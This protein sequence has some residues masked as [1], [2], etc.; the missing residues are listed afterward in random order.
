MESIEIDR[1]K[2]IKA[3]KALD[4][5]KTPGPDGLHPK[6][7]MEVA[8]QIGEPVHMIFVDS[9]TSC[10]LPNWCVLANITALYKGGAR[11]NPSNY[12]PVSLTSV[13]C[14]VLEKIIRECITGHINVEELLNSNQHGFTAGRSCLTNMLETFNDWMELYDEGHPLDVV[15][16]DFRKA[17]DR[18]PHERLLF[19]LRKLGINND[20]LTWIEYFLKD[21][22][23]RV[24]LNKSESSWNKV[25]SGVPQGSVLGPILFLLYVNDLPNYIKSS[26]KIFADDTKIYSK[27]DNNSDA[28][29]I[30][31]D[32]DDLVYWSGTWLLS[33]NAAKCKVMHI[34][35]NNNRVE[36]EMER[37]K[38]RV[39]PR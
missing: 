19:K 14:K 34:R 26:C 16:L 22:Q 29:R 9:L 1:S 27:V 33:F 15:F 3:L 30:Q 35:R 12:R 8:D 18:V 23:Q 2:V 21:R 38:V 11:E 37:C 24:V 39:C 7:L 28:E 5:N 32:L 17:F 4:P 25:Y 10:S 36:Y 6:V 31:Q 13:L 20:L